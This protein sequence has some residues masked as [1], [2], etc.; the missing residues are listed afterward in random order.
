V[1]P[2]DV[3]P[4]AKSNE[5][6]LRFARSRSAC[7]DDCVS[8]GPLR[9]CVS[10]STLYSSIACN[11]EESFDTVSDTAA[12]KNSCASRRSLSQTIQM[13]TDS[14]HPD[15]NNNLLSPHSAPSLP[16]SSPYVISLMLKLSHRR[17]S[18]SGT[19]CCSEFTSTEE[20]PAA[21]N[22]KQW[23]RTAH[24]SAVQRFYPRKFLRVLR[25]L[26]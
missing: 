14:E 7:A 22:E 15:S 8:D 20:T 19:S 13:V 5:D 11:L 17:A 18:F 3:S 25:N 24:F 6:Q 1:D 16:P 12:S 26:I 10:K 2:V 4:L 9:H 23:T 21:S